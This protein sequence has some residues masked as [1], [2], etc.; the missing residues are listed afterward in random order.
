MTETGSGRVEDKLP[1]TGRRRRSTPGVV[2][3]DSA[4]CFGDNGLTLRLKMRPER[5]GLR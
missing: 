2:W 1:K 3:F 5:G 4:E